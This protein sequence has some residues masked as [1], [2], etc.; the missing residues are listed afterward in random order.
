MTRAARQL[1]HDLRKVMEPNT[2]TR[3]R[4]QK[5]NK[6]KDFMAMA[7]PLNVTHFLLL[8]QTED[9]VNLRIAKFP[10]GP[11]LYFNVKAYTLHR[12]INKAAK[13]PRNFVS[14]FNTA[15]LL[16]LNNFNTLSGVEGKLM[17][18]MFQ[19]MFPTVN[20]HLVRLSDVRRVVL[21]H[22]NSEQDIVEV[23]HY[24]I[25]TKMV[26]VNKAVKRLIRSEVPDLSNCRDISEYIM[27]DGGA[28]DTEVEEDSVVTLAQDYGRMNR[29]D[30]RRALQLVEIGPRLRLSLIKILDGF[31]AGKTLYHI[32][33]K[34]KTEKK[35][36]Q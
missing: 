18:T 32:E 34:K 7:G 35:S 16:V 20:V 23:R 31:C 17:C 4:E 1:V 9:T 24:A 14:E 25:T 3:L 22:Y 21:C 19:G 15:P 12:D 26:G 5:Q 33:G 13:R 8:T 10:Q 27:R 30:N 6:I 2:A 36:K 11:T 28:S 29:K